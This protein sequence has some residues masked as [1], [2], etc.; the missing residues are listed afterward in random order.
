MKK[1]FILIQTK[2]VDKSSEDCA[3]QSK[4][5]RERRGPFYGTLC[6]DQ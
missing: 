3:L 6:P 1:V 5:E 2:R 4:R